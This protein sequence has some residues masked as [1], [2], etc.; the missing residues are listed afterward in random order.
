MVKRIC[1]NSIIGV[2]IIAVFLEIVI[3]GCETP[4]EKISLQTLPIVATLE[5]TGISGTS[6]ISGGRVYSSG[7]VSLSARGVCWNS[8]GKPTIDNS[9]TSDGTGTSTFTS[10]ITGLEE[11][12]VY[13]VKAYA[14]NSVGIAY[15]GQEMFTTNTIPTV[16][17]SEVTDITGIS[18]IAGGNVTF[19]GGA[20]VTSRGVCWSTDVNP[21][22]NNSKTVNGKNIGAF[23]SFLTGLNVNTTYYVRA[24]ASN[25]IGTSYGSQK[26]F[27]TSR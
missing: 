21:T 19:C 11:G 7:S 6:A 12:K 10:I 2:A 1:C 23:T 9:K 20:S 8:D 27:A 13:Y 18:A 16:T 25:S 26:S 14:I 4:S 24:Y 15:G 5:T 17:T 22:I 3:S